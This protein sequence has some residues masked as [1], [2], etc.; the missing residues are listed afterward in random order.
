[1]PCPYALRARVR[2]ERG[3]PADERSLRCWY[4]PGNEP[5]AQCLA[6]ASRE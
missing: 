1:M 2:G 5:C 3:L 6:L 4:G